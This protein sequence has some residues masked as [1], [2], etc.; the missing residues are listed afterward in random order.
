[1]TQVEFTEEPESQVNFRR[2]LLAAYEAGRRAGMEDVCAA[3]ALRFWRRMHE[4]WVQDLVEE[5]WYLLQLQG[6]A[7][8][9]TTGSEWVFGLQEK[10]W[11]YQ[12]RVAAAAK[13]APAAKEA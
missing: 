3:L 11:D 9:H 10:I 4:P 2:A 6:F 13:T 12:T 1:M 5:L 7:G 8:S